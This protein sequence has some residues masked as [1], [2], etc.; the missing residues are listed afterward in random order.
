M[1][2]DGEYYGSMNPSKVTNVLKKYSPKIQEEDEGS[3]D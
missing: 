2:I 1:V 3:V